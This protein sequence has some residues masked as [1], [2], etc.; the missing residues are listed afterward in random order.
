M[1]FSTPN[2][3]YPAPV[4]QKRKRRLLKGDVYKA[5]ENFSK[6]AKCDT[7]MDKNDH[8]KV[9][10]TGSTNN[11]KQQ[12]TKIW[13]GKPCHVVKARIGRYAVHHGSFH[14]LEPSQYVNDEV[15]HT[16]LK[17]LSNI[18]GDTYAMVSQTLSCILSHTAA[19]KHSHFLSKESLSMYQYIGGCYNKNGNHWVFITVHL[20][21]KYFY[22][23]DPYG[24]S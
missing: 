22:Y 11:A 17:L 14:T 2:K 5:N 4:K 15:M 3:N 19:E 10:D 6:K 18:Q 24:P 1:Q 12:L 13:N 20:E 7:V 21:H 23:L 16:Y 9:K 8:E